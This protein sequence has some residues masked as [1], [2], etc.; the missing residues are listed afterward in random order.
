MRALRRAATLTVPLLAAS[1]TLTACSSDQPNAASIAAQACGNM[2]TGQYSSP[3]PSPNPG[4]A[5]ADADLLNH[6]ANLAA[7]AAAQDP[8]WTQLAANLSWWATRA[9]N[10]ANQPNQTATTTP[11]EVSQKEDELEAQCRIA[12]AAADSQQ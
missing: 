10:R 9:T 2:G 11:D 1:V 6:A 3:D 8:R 5:Q 7:T 4:D 12:H